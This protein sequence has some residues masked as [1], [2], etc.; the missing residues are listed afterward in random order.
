MSIDLDASRATVR[1]VFARHGVTLVS[2]DSHAIVRTIVQTVI[3]AA[4]P[5]TIA[6]VRA[7]ISAYVPQ[8][9]TEAAA[10]L[11]AIPNVPAVLSQ[12]ATAAGLDEFMRRPMILVGD[13][14]WNDGAMLL[15]VAAHEL[16]HH[17]RNRA[18]AADCGIVCSLVWGIAYLMSESVRSW[19]EAT[20]YVNDITADVILH[21]TPPAAARDRALQ[22][23][24]SPVYG[25]MTAGARGIAQAAFAS[26]AASLARGELP[27]RDI[28]LVEVLREAMARGVTLTDAWAAKVSQ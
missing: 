18:E 20:C 5:L 27:G 22:S 6:D 4:T 26:A 16:S 23:L 28:A 17:R 1:A 2:P 7:R 25:S 13:L 21:G 9:P 11:S 15:G 8:V 3:A 24:A 19:E 14:A 12:G 10:L